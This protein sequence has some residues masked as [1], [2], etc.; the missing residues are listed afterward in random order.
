M[1][2]NLGT[3]GRRLREARTNCGVT[4]EVA[5]AKIGVPRTAIV[6]IEAGNRSISVIELSTL[7][8]LYHRSI[9][10]L[11]TEDA[12]GLAAEEDLVVTLYRSE[13]EFKGHPSIE[14][15]VARAVEICKEGTTFLKFLG[16][17]VR[18]GPPVYFEA[19]PE[20]PIMAMR[21]GNLT[22]VEERKRIAMG[23]GPVHQIA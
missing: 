10:D 1:S 3:L 6:H 12:G 2:I 20:T 23:D 4:Q 9:A 18:S 7:A 15:E 8:D 21:Q 19:E 14:R 17:R 16:N 11:F 5:A 22:A 13:D